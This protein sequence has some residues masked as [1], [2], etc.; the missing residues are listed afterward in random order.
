MSWLVA[1]AALSAQAYEVRVDDAGQPLRWNQMPLSYEVRLDGAPDG[2]TSE[3]WHKAIDESFASWTGVEGTRVLFNPLGKVD[4]PGSSIADGQNIVWFDTEWDDDPEVG[5]RTNVW[6]TQAGS[7]VGF[8][9]RV[10]ATMDWSLTGDGFDAQAALTHEV[11]HVIGLGH[12]D[13]EIATMFYALGPEEAFRRVLSEDDEEGVL[14]LYPHVD[15]EAP[16]FLSCN[17][18]GG[19]PSWITWLLLPALLRR[20]T[21]PHQ[22]G[23][24]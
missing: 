20:R 19:V 17:Q 13:V 4:A 24:Q 9:I 21:N 2:I 5:M 23:A 6:V 14:F 15:L 12:S 7:P 3:A 22:G 16:A 11:G 8:D 10:N 18:T 1:M